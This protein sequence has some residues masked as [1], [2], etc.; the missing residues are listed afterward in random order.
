MHLAN[1]LLSFALL[2]TSVS[3]LRISKRSAFE[4]LLPRQ[5]AC[6]TD[7]LCEPYENALDGC[8][9]AI[10]QCFCTNPVANSL[11]LCVNCAMGKNPTNAALRSQLGE[12][13]S[14]YE[15]LCG[16]GYNIP[17]VVMPPTSA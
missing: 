4:A 14:S 12:F 1:L 10:A 9:T 8:S 2:T 5:T 3:A 7:V 16:A 15:E 17:S 11:Q 6:N 13:V